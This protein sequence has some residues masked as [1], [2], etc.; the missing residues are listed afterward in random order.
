MK[1]CQLVLAL[2]M[3]AL[4]GLLKA[5][6]DPVVPGITEPF[7]DVT[8][9][10]P[11]AGTVS[12]RRFVEGDW[13]KQDQVIVELDKKLEELNVTRRKLVMDT[14]KTDLEGTRHLF[15]T[16]K[17]VSKDDL[18]KKELEYQVA[19][20]D[21]E[22]ALEQLRKRQI[23][24]PM[25]G[26]I[27]DIFPEVGED[28]R[29]QEPVVRLVE[30]RKAYL[31]CNLEARIGHALKVGQTVPVEAEAG[32][33]S[34]SFNGRITY[35]SPVVDPASGLLK[36]KVLLDNSDNKIRPGVAGKLRLRSTP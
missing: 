7:L 27:T 35:I 6:S 33:A 8:L 18:D 22:T 31:I 17:S 5:A 34:V 30:T 1:S 2:G 16:T 3:F 21:Y 15:Q 26:Q 25:D 29:P 4:P 13:V 20:V 9:S 19:V 32:D 12:Q 24:A 10:A 11:V 14:L 23:V 28:C 36:I